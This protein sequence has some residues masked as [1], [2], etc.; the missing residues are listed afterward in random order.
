MLYLDEEQVRRLLRWEELIAAM[1]RALEIVPELLS[2]GAQ[3][4]MLS[5]HS[6]NADDSG[7]D[8]E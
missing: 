4:A 6:R 2:S 7:T 5:L 3:K 8:R 1:E